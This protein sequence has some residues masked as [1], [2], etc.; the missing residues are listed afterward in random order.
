MRGPIKTVW[1][2]IAGLMLGNIAGSLLFA[3]VQPEPI[4]QE[5]IQEKDPVILGHRIG[6]NG[7]FELVIKE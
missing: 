2:V 1:V 4:Q 3:A 5:V 7:A 6:P